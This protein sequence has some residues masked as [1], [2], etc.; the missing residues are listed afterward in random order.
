MKMC[1]RCGDSF[2]KKEAEI[3]F[4][5]AIIS[6]S[7][8]ENVKKCICGECAVQA[9]ED[10]DDGIFFETCNE[11]GKYFDVM[12]EKGKFYDYTDDINLFDVWFMHGESCAECAIDAWEEEIA[13]Y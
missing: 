3:V 5:E 12:E 9:F 13:D 8:K 2:K 10:E 4:S 6:L 1:K 11:C 7:Y